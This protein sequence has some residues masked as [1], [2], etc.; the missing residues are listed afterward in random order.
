M[1]FELMADCY[2]G[3]RSVKESY[4]SIQK[5]I[6]QADRQW[7]PK[8]GFHSVPN[9]LVKIAESHN[10]KYHYSSPVSSVI[11]NASGVATGITLENGETKYADVVVVNADLVWAHNNLFKGAEKMKLKDAGLAK[12]LLGKPHSYAQIRL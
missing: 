2:N 7:Y 5:T 6:W 11:Y 3:P 12:K 4:A 9:S 1:D 8:G 10:A